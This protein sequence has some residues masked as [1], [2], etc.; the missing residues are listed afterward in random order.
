MT[1][2]SKN[3]FPFGLNSYSLTKSKDIGTKS[4][5]NNIKSLSQAEMIMPNNPYSTNMIK[6]GGISSSSSNNKFTNLS[7]GLNQ[8][9]NKETSSIKNSEG[10]SSNLNSFRTPGIIGKKYKTSKN[11]RKN[12]LT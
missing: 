11:S 4:K 5:S 12:N 8:I 9:D 1:S 10:N 7:I 2:L 6:T 3:K